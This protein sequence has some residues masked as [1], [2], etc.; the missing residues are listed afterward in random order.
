METISALLPWSQ[1]VLALL[2]IA[3]ILLQQNDSS[4]GGAFGGADS[5][6][7]AHRKRGA[8]KLVFNSTII[9]AILFVGAAIL[10]L[11]I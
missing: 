1:V 8:E 5:A 9:V 2:L 10:A 3:L 11:F 7:H 4:L 6:T